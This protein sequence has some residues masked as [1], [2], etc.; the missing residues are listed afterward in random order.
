[1]APTGEPTRRDVVAAGA[2]VALI[3]ATGGSANADTSPPPPKG[4]AT[5][6]GT[7]REDISRTGGHAITDLPIPNVLVSNGRDVVRTDANGAYTLPIEPG[8][9]IFVIKPAG[10]MLP[11]N[12]DTHIPLFSY[13][14]EPDGTPEALG[15]RYRGLTPTGPLPAYIDFPLV[16]SDEPSRFNVVLLTD[17][18]P[19][20]TAEIE[21]VRDDVVS[22]LIGVD[23]AFGITA[24]D[25]M[26]DDLSMYNRYNRIIG[27]IGL[28][29]WNIGGN[30]DL[31]FEAPDARHSRETFKRVFG[32][33]YYAHE[34]AG[35]TFIMLD[36]VDYLGPD[37]AKPG[38]SGKYRGFFSADQL[39]FVAALLKET[40]ADRLIVLVM[41]IPL[42][43]Y[44]D[45]KTPAMNT[46]NTADLLK[47]LG[48][49]PSVSFA[50]H[51]HS[52]EHHYLGK[53]EGFSGATPHHHHVLTAV[54]GSWWSG[55]LD[56]RGIACADSHDGTPNGFHILS[57]DG[58][59]YTTRYVPAAEPAGKQMRIV[60][61][62][63]MHE[64][65]PEVF[66]TMSMATL[67]RS[68]IT[69]DQ[70]ASASVLVN[71]FDGGPKTLVTCVIDGAA[72][73]TLIRTNRPDPFIQQVFG[74]APE[75]IKPWV[76]PIPSSHLWTAR[77]PQT[78]RP[79]TYALKVKVVDEYG[80]EHRDGMVLEV[81]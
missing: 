44:I 42:T 28:P 80:R 74:R 13:I 60:I 10:F 50:G 56:H 47:L 51:T 73:I 3:A 63:Q 67:L 38:R 72:P 64:D 12:L 25:L 9:A 66:R 53:A 62:A 55:P 49:R 27:K 54:S 70:V 65:D 71:V 48:D 6:S 15:L 79:G 11:S 45:P 40:P 29:W 37:P 36:N 32:A 59:S 19:E 78:L 58:A 20:S 8:M 61:E 43:T 17:P 16:R 1:M 46:A 21:F 77:L 22:G 69:A 5:V 33:T 14:Y 31:N 81:V 4:N 57:V 35:A 52:T 18:Q 26:F 75:T 24:G 30:H 76:K 7:I 68:P 34:Y 23:A 41:H 2:A 39:T